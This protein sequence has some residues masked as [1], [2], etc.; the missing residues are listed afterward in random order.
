LRPLH[1]R[2]RGAR[3]GALMLA[4]AAALGGAVLV[5]RHIDGWAPGWRPIAWQ[6]AHWEPRL[7]RAL[8]ALVDFDDD[9][10]SPVAWGGDCD[11]F[12]ATRNPAGHDHDGIDANCNGTVKPLR[13]SDADR[14]LLPP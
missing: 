4:L 14:G 11:D 7:S 2:L 12:D 13:P 9:G 5:V 10:Y 8:R 1:R 6:Y 3:A